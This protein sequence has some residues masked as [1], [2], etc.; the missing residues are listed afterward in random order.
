MAVRRAQRH[1]NAN[2]LSSL[3][4]RVRG[5]GEQPYGC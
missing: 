3:H 4:Q 1:A 5:D 2:F